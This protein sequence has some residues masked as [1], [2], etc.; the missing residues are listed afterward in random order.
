MITY[1][2]PLFMTGCI[3]EK[4][5]KCIFVDRGSIVNIVPKSTTTELGITVAEFS[6]S[7]MVIQGFIQQTRRTIGTISLEITMGDLLTYLIFHVIYSKTSY[8]LLLGHPWPHEHGIVAF[9]LHQCLKYY[10]GGE[11]KING[12]VKSFTKAKLH[13][14]DSKFLKKRHHT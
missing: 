12:D 1:Y 3:R 5:V 7:Q 8:K 2:Y 4:K 11:K 6:N 10:R 9:T 14:T 13:L